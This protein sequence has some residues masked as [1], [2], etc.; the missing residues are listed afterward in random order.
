MNWILDTYSNVYTTAM[1][2]P[3]DSKQI[4]ATAK[5]RVH[6]KRSALLGL[7]GRR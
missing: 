1:M 4:A 5:E 2:Q 6:V 7:F 3:H